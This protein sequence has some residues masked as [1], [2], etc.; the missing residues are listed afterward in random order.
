MRGGKRN[1]AGRKKGS[2]AKADAEARRK[3]VLTGETPLEYMLRIMRDEEIE[4]SRRDAMAVAAAPFVHSRLSAVSV[5]GEVVQRFELPDNLELAK[6]LELYR[7]SLRGRSL[8]QIKTIEH[9]PI[10]KVQSH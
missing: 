2:V 8:N 1:G 5:N 9:Q 7:D 10:T 6:A 4:T 3:A